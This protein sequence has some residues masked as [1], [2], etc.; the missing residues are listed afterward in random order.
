MRTIALPTAPAADTAPSFIGQLADYKA[1][2]VAAA[3][4]SLLRS[5]FVMI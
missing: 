4:L 5:I 3:I 1:F 2:I